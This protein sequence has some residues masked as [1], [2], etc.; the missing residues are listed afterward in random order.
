MIFIRCVRCSTS[1]LA[2][3]KPVG[4][5]FVCT[6]CRETKPSPK[7]GVGTQTPPAVPQQR[8]K[9]VSF[10]CRGCQE[11]MCGDSGQRSRC[12]RCKWVNDVPLAD[13]PMPVRTRTALPPGQPVLGPS[14]EATEQGA[15]TPNTEQFSVQPASLAAP[16]G[17]QP[18]A[19]PSHP[20]RRKR[21]NAPPTIVFPCRRC[22]SM[23]CG[24][25]GGHACCWKC[26]GVNQVPLAHEAARPPA[27]VP[28]ILVACPA[29][30]LTYRLKA[31]AK[32]KRMRCR[33]CSVVFTI[34][35]APTPTEG[36]A[37]IPKQ[38][39]PTH[40]PPRGLVGVLCTSCLETFEAPPEAWVQCAKCGQ[41][42]RSD[43][44]SDVTQAGSKL[45]AAPT[46]EELGGHVDL[47]Q[48]HVNVV[49]SVDWTWKSAWADLSRG[50]GIVAGTAVAIGL[51]WFM[52]SGL[53]S[54]LTAPTPERKLSDDERIRRM[55]REREQLHEEFE[56]QRKKLEADKWDK[57]MGR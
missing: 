53:H 41:I 20:D 36:T 30:A 37:A 1:Y 45:K 25:Q 11:M 21:N 17:A 18:A 7:G 43:P 24:P 27:A 5:D 6:R 34:P 39:Q 54:I 44:V 19:E 52:C 29:C 26:K 31:I 51:L 16:I 38:A 56:W 2:D 48:P 49:D 14:P 33:G 23:M 10:P 42:I 9:L 47:S 55:E 40:V 8:S 4:G 46:W 32:G 28:P 13:E 12:R 50:V 15:T 22:N 57:M 3:R 35:K